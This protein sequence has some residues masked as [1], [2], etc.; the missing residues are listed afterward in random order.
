VSVGWG[1]ILFG[2]VV[3]SAACRND[4]QISDTGSSDGASS[5]GDIAF[6]LDATFPRDGIACPGDCPSSAA[7][8]TCCTADG[9]CGYADTDPGR[10]ADIPECIGLVYGDNV[11]E[12]T[13]FPEG[14]DCGIIAQFCRGDG[15]C[16]N[17]IPEIGS[18]CSTQERCYYCSSLKLPRT[19]HCD[20]A[21]WESWGARPPCPTISVQ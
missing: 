10:Q 1:H 3:L 21:K 7:V 13:T 2:F 9:I 20:G 8:A 17:S 18:A 11:N 15:G 4:T 6:V 16:P 12:V 19:M 5:E 14:D